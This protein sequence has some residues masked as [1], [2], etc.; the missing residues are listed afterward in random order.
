[1]NRFLAA[2]VLGLSALVGCVPAADRGENDPRHRAIGPG[3]AS[4]HETDSPLGS[5]TAA[6]RPADTDDPDEELDE[7]RET[8][9]VGDE[10]GE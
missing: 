8:F 3:S 2:C 7:E 1:M 10:G 6:Q 5:R 4:G 9:P